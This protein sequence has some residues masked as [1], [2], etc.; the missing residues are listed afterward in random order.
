M[1][2]QQLPGRPA[3][4]IKLGDD[5][6]VAWLDRRH[7]LGKLRPIGSDTADLLL[8]DDSGTSGLQRLDLAGEVLVGSADPGVT[9]RRHIAL[10]ICK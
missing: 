10:Q 3:Q 6:G 1:R 2:I 7:Q 9:E 8:V 4:P 5:H